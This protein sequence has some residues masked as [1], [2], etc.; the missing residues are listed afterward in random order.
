MAIGPV[1]LIVLGFEHPQF[2]GEIIAELEKLRESDAVLVIDSLAVYN[3]P[4]GEREV[5]HLSNLT[6]DEGRR[7]RQQGRST[8]RPRHRRRSSHQRAVPQALQAGCWKASP[9]SFPSHDPVWTPTPTASGVSISCT[10]ILVRGLLVRGLHPSCRISSRMGDVCGCGGVLNR[11]RPG[12]RRE[13][14]TRP[15]ERRLS[16]RRGA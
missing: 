1:Q 16:E 15:E 12:R 10:R 14:I 8:R 11:E 4:T 7:A 5:E 9:G 13:M 6:T 2:H 3:D